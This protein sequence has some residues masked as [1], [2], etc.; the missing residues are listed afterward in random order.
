MTLRRDPPSVPSLGTGHNLDLSDLGGLPLETFLN[1]PALKIGDW[2][3]PHW[4]GCAADGEVIDMIDSFKIQ[5]IYPQGVRFSI[6]NDRLQ[7]L[8][9]GY[10]FYSYQPGDVPR[11]DDE[12]LRL[13]FTIDRPALGEQTLAVAQLREAHDLVIDPLSISQDLTVAVPPYQAMTVG[14]TLIYDWVAYYAGSPQPAY[15][16]SHLVTKRDIG[17]VVGMTLPR[18]EVVHLF[19]GDHAELS[20]RIQYAS[21]DESE[22][23]AQRVDIVESGPPLSPLLPAPLIQDHDGSSDLDPRVLLDG[24]TLLIDDYPDL[25]LG[26]QLVVYLEG[27]DMSLRGIRAD[28][29]TVISRQLQVR[30]EASWYSDEL[31]G[32]PLRLSYQVARLGAAWHSEALEIMVRRPLNLPMPLVDAAIPERGD[33]A[34]QGTVSPEQIRWGARVRVP[35]AAE[36]NEGEVW[37]HWDGHAS[38]G[39]VIIEQADPADPRLFHIPAAAIPANLGKR[40][41]VYYS[42]HLP[43]QNPYY[44]PAF[45]LKVANYATSRFPVIQ[46]HRD[47]LIDGKLSLAALKGDHA[48]FTLDAWPFMAP[49]QRLTISV[50][51]VAKAGGGALQHVMRDAQPVRDEEYDQGNVKAELPKVFL[52]RLALNSVLRVSVQVS[53][54]DGESFKPFPQLEPQLVA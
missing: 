35:Q 41:N 26:D 10:V 32:K 39:K 2:V 16:Q 38:T 13:F 6:S 49:G 47:E 28:V 27:P 50:A 1:D 40:L 54:D 37:M 31:I 4:R 14:D 29:S 48:H 42:L 30:V 18:S 44:S 45:D 33:E 9:G 5:I 25:Q 36:T 34:N 24:F 12:S 20:Y 15:S 51:G 53:F 22:S 21:G 52:Q 11:P 3:T 8:S 46:G 7:R 23:P 19:D 17:T 43:D